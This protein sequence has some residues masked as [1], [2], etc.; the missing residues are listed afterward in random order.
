VIAP[1][2]K[3]DKNNKGNDSRSDEYE[4]GRKRYCLY[5]LHASS[6]AEILIY[7]NL[8]KSPYDE[9]RKQKLRPLAK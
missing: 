7:R 8:G 5:G 1:N 4:N 3:N 9:N 6:V 2:D